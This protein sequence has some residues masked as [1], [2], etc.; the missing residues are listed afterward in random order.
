MTVMILLLKNAKNSVCITRIELMNVA[1]DGNKYLL[2]QNRINFI[3]KNPI[4]YISR[5]QRNIHHVAYVIGILTE[6]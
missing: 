3:S 5:N 6:N 2:S 1:V 4:S